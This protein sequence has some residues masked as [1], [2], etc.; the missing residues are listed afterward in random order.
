M[1][2]GEWLD[3]Q[4]E[5]GSGSG[6][7]SG[8]E[9]CPGKRRADAKHETIV[10]DAEVTRW[11]EANQT[12]AKKTPAKNCG[13]GDGSGS[14]AGSGCGTGNGNYCGSG[15]E[16]VSSSQQ[17]S[18]A[19]VMLDYGVLRLVMGVLPKKKWCTILPTVFAGAR[20]AS[21]D[22]RKDPE[23]V[24]LQRVTTQKEARRRAALLNNPW[25]CTAQ[26]NC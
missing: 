4:S 7:N 2:V 26:L 25:H 9:G 18:A 24:R 1:S 6:D 20:H 19:L 23:F 10:T 5:S 12:P 11:L 16:S 3:Y 13:S 8:G 21:V 15:S 14:G 22:G 17:V